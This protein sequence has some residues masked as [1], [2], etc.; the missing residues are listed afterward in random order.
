MTN[1]RCRYLS[2]NNLHE[3]WRFQITIKIMIAKKKKKISVF[4]FRVWQYYCIFW[5]RR[6]FG[7][8]RGQRAEDDDNFFFLVVEWRWIKESTKKSKCTIKWIIF[9]V[10][11]S[12]F[13]IIIIRTAYIKHTQKNAFNL[14]FKNICSVLILNSVVISVMMMM[15]LQ[16]VG[17]ICKARCNIV[18][19]T[20]LMEKIPK[21]RLWRNHAVL[22]AV[23]IC[24][25]FF[26]CYL[27]CCTITYIYAHIDITSH[28]TCSLPFFVVEPHNF[29]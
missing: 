12:S 29:F 15:I 27:Y 17:L 26:N 14:S 5:A 2:S 20:N 13:V 1:V 23:G 28:L 10:S 7:H 9:F 18:T 4:F 8:K 21:K 22:L 16:L 6:T 24:C 25:Y 3:T 11:Q 19:F